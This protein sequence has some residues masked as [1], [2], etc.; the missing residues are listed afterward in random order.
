MEHEVH[1]EVYSEGHGKGYGKCYEEGTAHQGRAGEVD[2]KV[3]DSRW[4]IGIGIRMGLC[5]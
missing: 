1:A 2:E 3:G 5:S 4:R